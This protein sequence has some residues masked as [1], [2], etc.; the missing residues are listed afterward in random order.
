MRIRELLEAVQLVNADV[1][2]QVGDTVIEKITY[3]SR[4]AEPGAI[5][6]AL[7]GMDVDGHS[8]VQDAYAKGV[9]Y[10]VVER[11]VELPADAAVLIVENTRVAL[12]KMAANFYGH[13][14]K[15]MTVVG[16]TGTKGKTTVCHYVR[17]LLQADGRPTGMVGT[18]GVFYGTV[19]ERTVNTTP[20]SLELQR[21]LRR[22]LDHGVRHV[23]MEVSSGGIMMHRTD[24]IHFDFGLFLNLSPDHI[25][26][27]EHPTFEHYRDCKARL[28]QMADQSLINVDDAHG[29]YMAGHARGRVRTFALG[30]EDAHYRGMNLVHGK[31]LAELGTRFQVQTEDGLHALSIPYPGEVSVYNALAAVAVARELGVDWE[32]LEKAIQSVKVKGRFEVL[33]V[34]EGIP[35]VVDY[36]HNRVALESLLSSLASYKPRRMI[37]VIGSV[38][39]RTQERRKELGEVAARYCDITILTEDNPDREDPRVIAQAM[40]DAMEGGKSEIHVEPRREAAIA[41][42]IGK[43]RPGDVVILA[44]KG[45]EEYNLVHGRQLPYSDQDVV[46]RIALTGRG[47]VHP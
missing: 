43:A 7:V 19:Q 31:T 14:S 16:V 33:N 2:G 10:F 37:L 34:F 18:V 38:G 23:V 6:V 20:E 32:V 5:F 24:D 15:E 27:R 1:L 46:R 44:G 30:R 25:G 45:H 13:P 9:R 39:N 8:F 3:N 47:T 17:D 12:S 36:A 26:E 35:V 40:A 22:M 29:A 42:A 28:F 4:V 41:L 11:A 21:T